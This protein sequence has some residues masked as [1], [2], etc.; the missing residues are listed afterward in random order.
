MSGEGPFAVVFVPTDDKRRERSRGGIHVAIAIK[1]ANCQR[2]RIGKTRVDFALVPGRRLEP[3]HALAVAATG[4]GIQLAVTIGIESFD[5]GRA[6][7]FGDL[8]LRPRAI[9]LFWILPPS[10]GSAA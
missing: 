4:D 7:R 8:M 9:G 10:E 5:I 2:V 3:K 1:I 6:F